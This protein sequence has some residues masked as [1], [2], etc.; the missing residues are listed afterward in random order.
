MGLIFSWSDE[1]SIC[2]FVFFPPPHPNY[3]Q[4]KLHF[5]VSCS[6]HSFFTRCCR[7]IRAYK[8]TCVIKLN[9]LTFNLA[10]QN[11]I[12]NFI[13]AKNLGNFILLLRN[14]FISFIL[15]ISIILLFQNKL[16]NITPHDT[17]LFLHAILSIKTCQ[18]ACASVSILLQALHL[19]H[20]C[21][22]SN[23]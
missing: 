19:V 18:S 12:A 2:L 8:N 14:L 6:V 4:D 7:S 10:A 5:V 13:D 3:I 15:I 17:L 20:P 21:T 9:A 1:V 22:Q 16:I 11:F 23:C